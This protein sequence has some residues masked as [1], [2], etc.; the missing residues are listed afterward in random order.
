M[1]LGVALLLVGIVLANGVVIALYLFWTK[2][3][4]AD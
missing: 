4:D 3:R 2:E 1:S